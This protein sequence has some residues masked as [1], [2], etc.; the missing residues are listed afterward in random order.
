MLHFFYQSASSCFSRTETL[1]KNATYKFRW[2]ENSMQTTIDDRKLD[3][4]VKQIVSP[5]TCGGKELFSYKLVRDGQGRD[6]VVAEGQAGEEH[7][8]RKL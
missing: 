3:T 2:G 7:Q 6:G 4:K 5:K 8:A 1:V